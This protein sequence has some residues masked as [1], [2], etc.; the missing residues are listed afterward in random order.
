MYFP[1]GKTDALDTIR[2]YESGFVSDS[3]VEACIDFFIMLHPDPQSPFPEVPYQELQERFKTEIETAKRMVAQ[4]G[5]QIQ[6]QTLPHMRGEFYRFSNS[7]KYLYNSETIAVTRN[8]LNECWNGI[9][10]WRE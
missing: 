2:K 4:Y 5:S 8:L 9:G 1:M 7:M 6:P 10:P 3:M